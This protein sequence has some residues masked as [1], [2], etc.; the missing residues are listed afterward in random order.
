MSEILDLLSKDQ[1]GSGE[2]TTLFIISQPKVGKTEAFL[3]LPDSFLIDIENGS[4]TYTGRKFNVK[5]HASDNK[6]SNRQALSWCMGEL[7]KLPDNQKP[8]FLG[9]DTTTALEDIA[10]DLALE[11]YKQTAMGKGFTGKDVTNLA[12]GAG[13]GYLREAFKLIYD[14]FKLCVKN[15]GGCV[16]FLGHSKS[17]SINKNGQDLTAKDVQLTGRIKTLFTSDMD[18][19]GFLYRKGTSSENYI[20]FVTQEQ[21]LFSG[22][23]MPYLAGKEFM[24]SSKN[25]VTGALTTHWNI[26]FPSLLKK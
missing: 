14:N 10:A 17:G 18:A 7:M 22:T 8:R 19:N 15:E 5:Q 12:Q 21:D 4:K 16:V 13:Y 25:K 1:I 3:Q 24:F 11:N 23:R 2:P 26:I 20:S 6:I 9:I